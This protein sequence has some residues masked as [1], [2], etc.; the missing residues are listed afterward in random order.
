MSDYINSIIATDVKEAFDELVERANYEYGHQEGYSGKINSV[1]NSGRCVLKEKF[2]KTNQKKAD[3]LINQKLP[4]MYEGDSC[5]IEL[6]GIEYEVVTISKERVTSKVKP[7]YEDRYAIYPSESVVRIKSNFYAV[8]TPVDTEKTK[9]LAEE[10]AIKKALEDGIPYKIKK[11]KTLIK[12]DTT[13]TKMV[14]NRKKYKTK[15]KRKLK[16]NEKLIEYK[17]YIFFG[18][19][20]S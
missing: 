19:G 10:C 4:N 15:P 3:K 5:Y 20:R 9:K 2:N 16:S 13:V 14:I 1:G 7:K 11:E 17:K 8:D 18:V 12:G 6:T